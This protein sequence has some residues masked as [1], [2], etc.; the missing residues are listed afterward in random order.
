MILVNIQIK[1]GVNIKPHTSKWHNVR[2]RI[3][4]GV[5]AIEKTKLC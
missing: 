5:T 1:K 3:G 4:L 2:I